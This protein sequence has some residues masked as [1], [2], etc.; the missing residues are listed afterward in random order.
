MLTVG[1]AALG[2]RDEQTFYQNEMDFQFSDGQ[3][4]YFEITLEKY[5]FSAQLSFLLS[6]VWVLPYPPEN[7]QG[8][9]TDVDSFE[10]GLSVGLSVGP[11]VTFVYCKTE[12][13]QSPYDFNSMIRSLLKKDLWKPKEQNKTKKPSQSFNLLLPWHFTFS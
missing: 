4:K 13:A 10:V 6:E 5:R 12:P 8:R 9:C 7:R 2:G 11:S 1:V 3:W